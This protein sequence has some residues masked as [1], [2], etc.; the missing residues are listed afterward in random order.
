MLGMPW[1]REAG[2]E[3]VTEAEW[4]VGTDPVAMLDLL[5][6]RN[7]YPAGH[8]ALKVQRPSDRK[9]RLA[10]NAIEFNFWNVHG[11]GKHWKG[12]LFS[13]TQLHDVLETLYEAI[14]IHNT[15]PQ[16]ENQPQILRD[17]FI[18]PSDPVVLPPEAL[19]GQVVSLAQ[20]AFDNRNKYG[21]LDRERLL[22]MSDALEEAGL[23][24]VECKK[25]KGAL[26]SRTQTSHGYTVEP[27]KACNRTG[28][29]LPPALAHLRSAGPHYQGCWAVD[30]AAGLV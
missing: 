20:A 28:R 18:D 23:S 6:R 12:H 13:Y 11:R 7:A 29:Q 4:S 22:I 3:G 15:E 14:R 24:E 25:C 5:T 21:F 17:I 8:E 30:L 10:I 26:T 1:D 19:T 16:R 27:C 2:G 9:L